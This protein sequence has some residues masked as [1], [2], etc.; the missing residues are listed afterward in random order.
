MVA[1]V[2][3]CVH[4]GGGRRSDRNVI[5]GTILLPMKTR[6]FLLFLGIVILVAGALIFVER[7]IGSPEP[8]PG[9]ETSEKRAVSNTTAPAEKPLV[10][11]F[12]FNKPPYTLVGQGEVVDPFAP[13]SRP[14]GIE[15]DLFKAAL[16]HTGKTFIFHSETL[17]R[18]A[19]DV[20]NGSID[21]AIIAMN[22]PRQPG[23]YYSN[24]FLAFENV[25][26]TRR[27]A[28]LKIEKLADMKGRSVSAWQG[29]STQHNAE[30]FESLV[31]DN[32]NYFESTDQSSQYQMFAE[33]HVDALLI[34]KH[35]FL[36]YQRR[37]PRREEVVFHTALPRNPA[38]MAF[39]DPLLRDA[40][41][42]G[43]E[44]IAASGE[45]EKIFEKYLAET[46]IAPANR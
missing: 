16:A 22:Q 41:N 33:H 25:I 13:G 19:L 2:F 7:K 37:D 27:S 42:E 18:I 30:Y 39:R 17:S 6:F 46:S 29:A 14:Y 35:I 44:R 12:S 32:P 45:R 36:W 9:V 10:V 11:G 15:P 24:V 8:M 31:K 43:L 5:D 1:S 21:A 4:N 28:N 38:C 40:F 23:V 3:D 26:V 34:D 20:S